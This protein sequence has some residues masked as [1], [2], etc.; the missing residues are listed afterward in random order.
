[1]F[2]TGEVARL[3]PVPMDTKTTHPNTVSAADI[4]T[5]M[6]M[7]NWREF[8]RFC[9]ERRHVFDLLSSPSATDVEGVY[10]EYRKQPYVQGLFLS[11][12]L[13]VAIERLE[14]FVIKIPPAD[15]IAPLPVSTLTEIDAKT[16]Q[17]VQVI[18]A[19]SSL[20]PEDRAKLQALQTTK[21][22]ERELR[23]V[24]RLASL[25]RYVDFKL[26]IPKPGDQK[27]QRAEAAD[28][29][30]DA[31]KKLQP[32]IKDEFFLEAA[33]H[34]DELTVLFEV[35]QKLPTLSALLRQTQP[36]YLVQKVSPDKVY[37]ARAKLLVN[38]LADSC[39]RFYAYC[40]EQVLHELLS[41]PWLDFTSDL[42]DHA[43]LID[44]ALSRHK[45]QYGRPLPQEDNFTVELDGA[46][47][48]ALTVDPSWLDA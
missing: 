25:I 7:S 1:M 41:Y 18:R 43:G 35:R 30:D 29:L 27:K 46:W 5:A 31:F 24:H 23:F 28:A 48:P 37:L 22:M 45:D 38:R 14:D 42:P 20:H 39:F 26:P 32:V 2:K 13:S 47:I 12:R 17:P 8:D 21:K 11:G 9:Q 4:K 15:L 33:G 6:S 44:D 19:E 10:A 16:R 36:N 34:E 40:D 3:W